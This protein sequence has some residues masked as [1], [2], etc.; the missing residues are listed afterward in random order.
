MNITKANV[1]EYTLVGEFDIA[2]SISPDADSNMSKKVTLRF[3]MEGVNLSEILPDALRTKRINWANNNRKNFN[4]IKEGSV[5]VVDYRGGRTP[6]DPVE[7]FK[8]RFAS[9][10]AA[11]R[12]ALLAELQAMAK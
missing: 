7:A 9:A 3:K 8:A 12:E 11:E 1:S 4:S 6:V 10:S 2:A 5:Y